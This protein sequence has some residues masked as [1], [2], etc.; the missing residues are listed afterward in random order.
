M[1][2]ICDHAFSTNECP[3]CGAGKFHDVNAC[4]LG[5]ECLNANAFVKCIP[6]EELECPDQDY[7][8]RCAIAAMQGLISDIDYVKCNG[9]S[10]V[11]IDAHDAAAAMLAERNRRMGK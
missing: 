1:K 10:I 4:C 6:A 5:F 9:W 2:Y 8:D 3:S 7:L 11:A